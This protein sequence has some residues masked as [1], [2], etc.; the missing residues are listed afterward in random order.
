ME[1]FG[2][3]LEGMQLGKLQHPGAILLDILLT[4]V[5]KVA[6]PGVLVFFFLSADWLK[7]KE[8]R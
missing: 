6:N 7:P 8:C 5:C 2:N 3:F 1:R 4:G